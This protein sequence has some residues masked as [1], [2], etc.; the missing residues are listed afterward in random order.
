MLGGAEAAEDGLEQHMD[1]P[2]S[3]SCLPLLAAVRKLI[4]KKRKFFLIYKENR[5]GAVAKTC[6]TNGLLIYGEIFSH[7]LIY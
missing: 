1:D 7:F 2:V 4:K 3:I 5:N 6:M